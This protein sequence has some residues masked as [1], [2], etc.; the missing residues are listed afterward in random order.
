MTH[1]A[2]ETALLARTQPDEGWQFPP[3]RYVTTSTPWGKADYAYRYARGVTSYSCPGHG[4]FKL[5]ATRQAQVHPALSHIGDNGW[6]EED[7]EWSVVAVTFPELFPYKHV[8]HAIN[9]L[10]NYWPGAW[11]RFS[12]EVV[13]VEESYTLQ[14]QAF[15]DAHE[16]DWVAVAARQITGTDDVE[17]WAYLGGVRGTVPG[18]RTFIVPKADYDTRTQFG[19]VVPA[20]L[21]AS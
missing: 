17:V 2:F 15:R 11:T 18:E 4:G 6:Y 3:S 12:G 9:S 8:E 5:S 21:V 14:Q 20:E 13:P 16:N 10:K 1:T 7:C 19:Y